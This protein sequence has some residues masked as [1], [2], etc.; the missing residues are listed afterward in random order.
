FQWLRDT[1]GPAG[2]PAGGGYDAIVVD[3]P[4]PD[5]TATAK[6]YS[7]EFYALARR[8]LAPGGR[9]V[10]QAGS[11]YFTPA[12]FSCALSTVRSAGLGTVPYHVDVPSFGDWGFI[13]AAE[14]TTPPL[15]LSIP[16]Q[17]AAGRQLRFVDDAVLGAAAVFPAD[18]R[19]QPAQPSTLDDPQILQLAARE[20][21]SGL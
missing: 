7:T 4:D 21:Q 15:R 10:V 9:M 18:R 5:S 6:L 17:M 20:W 3:L 14:G 11:P 2:V 16:A 1:R 12:T 13:L 19:P 8:A